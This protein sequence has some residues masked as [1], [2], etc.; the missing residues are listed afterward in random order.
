VCRIWDWR[1]AADDWFV[2]ALLEVP[3]G[4][5]GLAHFWGD[6]TLSVF[7]ADAVEV[8]GDGIGNDNVLCETGETCLFT[9]NIASDQGAEPLVDRAFIGAG[10]QVEDVTLI[11][12]GVLVKND[13]PDPEG[14]TPPEET[15]AP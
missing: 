13:P 7:L 14:D 10:G 15:P 4:E 8:T 1:I 5:T 3:T 12:H 6:A 11:S 9:P 2:R